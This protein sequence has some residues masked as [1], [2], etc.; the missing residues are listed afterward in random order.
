[1]IDLNSYPPSRRAAQL[2]KYCGK[3]A[4]MIEL[5]LRESKKILKL[6]DGFIITEHKNGWVCAN[7]GID[8]SNVPGNYVTFLP[9]DPD[10]TAEKMRQR[11]KLLCGVEVAVVIIDSQGR[12]FRNGSIGIAIGSSGIPALV[13]KRGEK[14]LFNYR[15]KNTEVALADEI[16]SAAS[17]IMGETNEGIPVV[18]IRGLK[19][20]KKQGKAHDLIRSEKTDLFRSPRSISRSK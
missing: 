20:P 9:Q 18:V 4:R 3:D 16:A 6:G 2:A 7:A 10:H 1:M 8:Y 12:P 19:Y 13:H 17:L 15:L 5:I 14:D 11:I